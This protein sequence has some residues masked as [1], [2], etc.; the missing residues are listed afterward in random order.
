MKWKEIDM[1]N[2]V[3]F[4]FEIKDI[5]NILCGEIADSKLFYCS[6]VQ[7]YLN[8]SIACYPESKQNGEETSDYY[9]DLYLFLQNGDDI[10]FNVSLEIKAPHLLAG[11][12]GINRSVRNKVLKKGEKYIKLEQLL[13]YDNFKYFVKD[14]AIMLKG[15]LKAERIVNL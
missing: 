12:N 3:T 1:S 7:W 9:L 8:A 14:N 2:E 15:K 5:N 4:D 13:K 11:I 10:K 6:S